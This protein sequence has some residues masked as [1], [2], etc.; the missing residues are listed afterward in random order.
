MLAADTTPRTDTTTTDLPHTPSPGRRS[1]R[2]RR[3]SLGAVVLATLALALSACGLE[4]DLTDQINGSRAQNGARALVP[5]ATITMKAAGWAQH[6][7]STRRLVHSNLAEGN[8]LQWRALAENIGS[9]PQSWSVAQMNNAFMNSAGHRA[10]MLNPS[11]NYIG[12]GMVTD[13]TGQ[14]WVAEEFMLL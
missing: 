9:F 3:A 14:T 8:N 5:N 10:N 11:Y 12:V 6:M 1:R 2:M 7:A 4:Q 13:S